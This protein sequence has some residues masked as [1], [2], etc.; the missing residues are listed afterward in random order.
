MNAGADFDILDVARNGRL[1]IRLSLTEL[2]WTLPADALVVPA[3]SSANLGELGTAFG[4]ACGSMWPKVRA[5]IDKEL[6]DRDPVEIGRPLLV[7][8][9]P[10]KEV[11]PELTSLILAVSTLSSGRSRSASAI[12]PIVELADR[13]KIR[14]LILPLIGSGAKGEPPI[15]VARSTLETLISVDIRALQEVI[16]VTRS[17][18]A[19]K[20]L[21]DHAKGSAPRKSAFAAASRGR[22]PKRATA[23][24]LLVEA[25]ASLSM[26]P[27]PIL[28]EVFAVAGRIAGQREIDNGQ[29]TT[30]LVLFAAIRLGSRSGTTSEHEFLTRLAE[31]VRLRAGENYDRLLKEY[32]SSPPQFESRGGEPE[33]SALSSNMQAVL[34]KAAT[35]ASLRGTTDVVGVQPCILA[36]LDT[37][38]ANAINNLLKI[39]ANADSLKKELEIYLQRDLDATA[40]SICR[41]NNDAAYASAADLLSID[42]E[43][44]AF[45]HLA[46]S[47]DVPP[48]LSI[49]VFGDWGAGKSF[50]MERMYAQIERIKSDDEFKASDEFY[51]DIVQI[52]FNAWHYIETNLWASLVEFIFS[53]LDRWLRAQRDLRDDERYEGAKVDKLFEQ[54]STSRELRLDSYRDLMATRRD[55]RLAEQ[56]LKT[57]QENSQEALQRVAT[58]P[59]ENHWA[60]V[61]KQVVAGLDAKKKESLERALDKLG[62][63]ETSKDLTKSVRE[64]TNLVEAAGAQALRARTLANALVARLG[65]IQGA[66]LAAGAVLVAPFVAAFIVSRLSISLDWKWLETLSST[67]VG[68]VTSLSAAI[69][70]TG[71]WLK[72]ARSGLDTINQL[73]DSIDKKAAESIKNEQAELAKAQIAA[74]QARQTIAE[75]EKRLAMAKEREVVAKQDF[76]NE[77]AR[78]RLNRFIRGKVADASYSKHLGI[79]AS[80]RKDFGQLTELMR[81]EQ[82]DSALSE[83]IQ[84]SNRQ[85]LK[86]LDELIAANEPASAASAGLLL[87]SE[88]AELI[89]ERDVL[90]RD[91]DSKKGSSPNVTRPPDLPSFERIILYIDDLDRCPPDKVVDVLQAI[92]LLLYFP[93]FVV[94]VAVDARWV[95]RSLMVRYK[96]L[97]SD[98]RTSGARQADGSNATDAEKRPADAQDYIE[99]LFQL[100]YWV[101]EMNAET[102]ENFVGSLAAAFLEKSSP[103]DVVIKPEAV[104]T[105]KAEPVEALGGGLSLQPAASSPGLTVASTVPEQEGGIAPPSDTRTED[106]SGQAKKSPLKFVPMTLS[107]EERDDLAAFASFVGSTP[108]RAKRYLNLYLLLN[109]ILKL[110]ATQPGANRRVNQRAIISLLA[111]VT[112][113]GPSNAI[114]DILAAPKPQFKDLA[115]LKHFLE[116]SSAPSLGKVRAVISKLIEVNSRDAIAQNEVM[117]AALQLYAPTVRRYSF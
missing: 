58:R 76:Q 63:T 17:A 28:Q 30:S 107:K 85:Y 7:P 34:R 109:T 67:A 90:K 92:H 46:A 32:F 37:P 38:D 113:V 110:G 70:V 86:K 26:S 84:K 3:S 71:T 15:K 100:P 96:D 29:L 42:D 13:S 25:L 88:K 115:S 94:V 98:E 8:L 105:E 22:R 75:A 14:R 23:A 72:Q 60:I 116:K 10:L 16:L 66:V 31:L 52:R 48:P 59:I 51:T 68:L 57:A 93:L 114:F 106:A 20:W 43:V 27:S 74:D 6:Q 45:A 78:G 83:E 80:I 95:S 112:S 104:K 87:A 41:F 54:L 21:Q 55:L 73:R 97:L 69:A 47:R 79:I 81:T 44:L 24:G 36:L 61:V 39:E 91:L 19:R 64:L 53:E 11:A 99:K 82:A 77:T 56:E 9:P 33:I 40:A 65:S 102:S 50:F 49:S 1:R 12:R 89:A 18:E 111:I 108:R 4:R 2:P 103:D 35:L 117:L 62:L 101:R 5:A